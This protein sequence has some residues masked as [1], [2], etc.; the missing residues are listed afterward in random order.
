MG[1]RL[2]IFV[3]LIACY[4]CTEDVSDKVAV[5]EEPLFVQVSSEESGI[6]FKNELT[7]NEEFNI[8]TYRNYYNGGGVAL[9]DVNNDGLIDIYLTGNLVSN[10]LYL[11][12]GNFQFEDVTDKA[13]VAGNR[14]WST[15]VSMADINGDGWLDIYICNSGDIQGDNKENELFI[16]NGDGTFTEKGQEYGLADNGFSTHAAF[17]D[18]DKDGDL[19]VY[20]LNNSY[21][22]IGS[23]NLMQNKRPE[24]DPVGG[25]KLFRNDGD[26]FTDVSEE[27]GIY[28]SIIGFGLGVTVGDVNRDGW[29]DIFISNDF[30]ERDYLYINNG[31]GTFTEQLEDAMKSIS[32]ASMGADMADVNN[33][34]YMDIFVTDMLPESIE[35]LKQVTTFEN[36][37]KLMYNVQNKYHYQFTR[38]MLHL[39][40]GDGTFT[41]VGRLAGVEAT[42]WSWGALIFDMDNDG[43]KDIFVANG[44]YQDITDLDYLNFIQDDETKRKIITEEGVDYKG[45][46]DPIP[47][48]PVSNYAFRNNGDLSFTN[49]ADQWGLGE[50][51]H[52]NGSAYGDLDN[53]GDLDLVV[54]NVNAVAGVFRN[55][56]TEA[57]PNSNYL[58][59]RLHGEGKNTDAV[60]T[61]IIGQLSSGALYM[62]QQPTRGFESSVDP[63][64]HIGLGGDTIIS[65]LQIIWPDD[66]LT[67]LNQVAANQSIELFQKDAGA[68]YQYAKTISP[69]MFT[70]ES[71][72]IPF[73]HQENNFVDFDRDR[74]IYHMLSNEGPAAALGDVNGDGL[75][76]IFM[77]GAKDQAGV[78]LIQ[79]ETGEFSLSVQSVFDGDKGS[80]DVGALFF[81]ADGDG[82]QDLFVVSGGNEFSLGAPELKNRLYINDGSG[83][84]KKSQQ[85]LL[86]QMSEIS[87]VVVAA[88][89]DGDGDQDL[90]IG[91]RAVPFKYGLSPDSYL[92]ENDGKGIFT[93]VSDEK[94][95]D[96]AAIG[97]VTDARWADTDGDGDAD[98]MMV[99]EWM[100]PVLLVNEGGVLRRSE[101]QSVLDQYTGWY[102][103]I[104]AHDIDSDGDM[105][106]VL[107]N[108]GLNSRFQAS[109]D[110]PVHLYISDFDR[111]GAIEHIYAQKEDD[112]NE[113]PFAL[114]HEL[115]MQMPGLKKRYLKYK[116]YNDQTVEQIF[117]AEQLKAA[118]QKE[119][120]ELRSAVLVNKGDGSF[121]WKALPVEAQ[122]APVYAFIFTDIDNDGLVD[123]IAGGNQYR[124]KPEAGRYDGSR[125]MVLM[126]RGEGKFESIPG[127][128]TG[129]IVEGEIRGFLLI[130][131]TGRR[132]IVI[133]NNDVPDVFSF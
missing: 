10:K 16:N 133:R 53:D 92:L 114:K 7:F 20:L 42:D 82:D 22:A 6:D 18:Y 50:P 67:V 119:V 91:T 41:E 64:L 68:T 118:T 120:K 98:L 131:S 127:R 126:N 34:G 47:I 101:Q 43:F 59:L 130:K 36:W 123:L 48:N 122:L 39:N 124:A 72:S 87:S 132:L 129:F 76:D 66:R 99:G 95:P 75:K 121:A 74:L 77:G 45:L 46:I 27:A 70:S 96:L 90:F 110:K 78:I 25:D 33:D 116:D 56:A 4:A 11:N 125:G 83:E 104:E 38:N 86:S 28:G 88:D 52:S 80:E 100:A 94:A 63:V 44:I 81:D 49:M 85:P 8:Y 84:F 113:Y 30:F 54:N 29:Q 89:Y 109:A 9:G 40:N 24:R 102:N 93:N 1:R 62:E 19:D 71:G 3:S 111:N 14:A 13:G 15:G 32:A 108:H 73:Q 107:G 55:R 60:G 17:F 23:F 105:D 31:D 97:M 128:E 37:D 12:K 21:Q 61:R 65:E 51:V 35:R 103:S 115:V 79:N 69:K 57:V 5:P 58:R 117:S 106:F 2:V 112:G 26:V